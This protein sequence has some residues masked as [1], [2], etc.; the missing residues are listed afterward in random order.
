MRTQA[1]NRLQKQGI[2]VDINQLQAD[3][4][5]YGTVRRHL[6]RCLNAEREPIETDDD[7]AKAGAQHIAALQNRTA[8]VT[9][10]TLSQLQAAGDIDVFVDITVS[11]PECGMHATAQEFIDSDGCH[12]EEP[13]IE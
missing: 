12:C 10:N 8:A 11:C 1:R 5:S 2:D 13:T 9:E 3:F 4:V 7:P 6:K